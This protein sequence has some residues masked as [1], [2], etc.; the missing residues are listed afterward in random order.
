MER[1]NKFMEKFWLVAAIVSFIYAV[2]KIGQSGLA[3]AAVF[4]IV[5]MGAGALF[6][7]RYFARKRLGKRDDE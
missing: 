3:D 6:S 7:M 4:L 2:Y 5:P 1:Y